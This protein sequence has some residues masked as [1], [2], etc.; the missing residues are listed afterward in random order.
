MVPEDAAV[1]Q[2]PPPAAPPVSPELRCLSIGPFSDPALSSQLAESLR[3]LGLDPEQRAEEGQVWMGYWVLASFATRELAR[4]AAQQLQS[5]GV[6]D[7]YV[8]PGTETFTVS[9][10]LFSQRAGAERVTEQAASFGV[11]AELRDR[12]RE[13]TVYQVLV[14][15]PDDQPPP[16]LPQ[17]PGARDASVLTL[18]CQ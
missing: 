8:I 6:P 14:A 9:L 4:D 17:G 7:A 10:G 3:A 18:E 13:G 12:Y 16:A 11:V 1:A 5:R 15:L 2:P